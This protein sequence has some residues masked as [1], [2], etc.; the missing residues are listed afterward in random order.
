MN[1]YVDP[2]AAQ[3]EAPQEKPCAQ[4]LI[5]RRVLP[6]GVSQLVPV[7]CGNRLREVCES[8]S[9]RYVSAFKSVFKSG[10]PHIPS[11]EQ[12]QKGH[13]H[14]GTMM[15]TLTAP[16]FGKVHSAYN[17]SP[18]PERRGAPLKED[19]YHY[20]HAVTWNYL[21]PD[22]VKSARA[23]IDRAAAPYRE[24]G[25]HL[26]WRGA[27]EL[28]ARLAPH[29]HMIL[30]AE[31]LPE[32]KQEYI[33]DPQVR[34]FSM[35]PEL[36]PYDVKESGEGYLT[37]AYD[38]LTEHHPERFP[39]REVVVR[40]GGN[41]PDAEV[42][43]HVRR[44]KGQRGIWWARA[45]RPRLPIAGERFKAH[46]EDHW[47]GA[48]TAIPEELRDWVGSEGHLRRRQ[49]M[50]LPLATP[51]T[52]KLPDA[53]QWGTGDF[54][55][56]TYTDP[57][58]GDREAFHNGTDRSIARA[59][60]YLAKAVGYI[61]KNINADGTGNYEKPDADTARFKHERRTRR[62]AFATLM[63]F[64][65]TQEMR[66]WHRLTSEFLNDEVQRLKAEHAGDW[67]FETFD[68]DTASLA[69]T[70]AVQYLHDTMDLFPMQA[71]S[72]LDA[73][74][75]EAVTSR[76][77]IEFWID[78]KKKAAAGDPAL[79]NTFKWNPPVFALEALHNAGVDSALI[80]AYPHT[81][82]R[83]L[84]A[85]IRHRLRRVV[86]FFGMTSTI[87]YSSR[88]KAS[89][90]S[91]RKERREYAEACSAADGLMVD[92]QVEEATY[93][94]VMNPS[95]EDYEEARQYGGLPMVPVEEPWDSSLPEPVLDE[96]PFEGGPGVPFE[97]P[98]PEPLP[99]DF[100]DW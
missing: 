5:L 60:G 75:A 28:Q 97:P 69:E 66:R 59:E 2:D 3:Q 34:R 82:L 13:R 98:P 94:L 67:T 30:S 87:S 32:D 15:I 91:V 19:K 33:V 18:D 95:R 85:T 21:M 25:C 8:C 48:S 41:E 52:L 83:R 29:I 90:A 23:V 63:D 76:E 47:Q 35:N 37:F 78:G 58:H 89:L 39:D 36:I 20:A 80:Q 43:L 6:S 38:D 79:W 50:G 74:P 54:D 100:E 57:Q 11:D 96:D 40:Q 24:A 10:R 44:E 84:D 22:L 1:D 56:K 68:S 45:V 9:E 14:P 27:V 4:P 61:A 46:F 73:V 92:P 99:E 62:E 93:E 49:Q 12:R 7:R 31:D 51:G 26:Q 17:G 72:F 70:Q 16:S 81:V 64:D 77:S 42:R 86:T 88:W 71:W 65:V 53:V 55:R